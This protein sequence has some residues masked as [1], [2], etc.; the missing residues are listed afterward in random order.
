VVLGADRGNRRGQHL[1]LMDPRK[2]GTGRTRRGP[3]ELGLS[4]A[5]RRYLPRSAIDR[6][7][8]WSVLESATPSSAL[9]KGRS[10]RCE[11]SAFSGNCLDI[12]SA[13]RC[14]G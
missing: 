3:G 12:N 13:D 9:L 5:W 6:D 14:A 4:W 2:L 7:R 10:R 8:A 1:I 11:T